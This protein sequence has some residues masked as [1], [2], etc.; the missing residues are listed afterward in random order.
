[1]FALSLKT[2]GQKW[3]KKG[4]LTVCT[5]YF[6]YTHSWHS[7]Y[8]CRLFA[9]HCIVVVCL[10]YL[11]CRVVWHLLFGWIGKW[12]GLSEECCELSDKYCPCILLNLFMYTDCQKMIWMPV[13]N[14]DQEVRLFTARHS[15][16]PTRQHSQNCCLSDVITFTLHKPGDGGS[17]LLCNDRIKHTVHCE[18]PKHN[19]CLDSSLIW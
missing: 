11:W 7:L 3:K 17:L 10:L 13:V 18:N 6:N 14:P 9:W 1:M 16:S 5:K 8:D 19:N 15:V 12:T 2:E 4:Q